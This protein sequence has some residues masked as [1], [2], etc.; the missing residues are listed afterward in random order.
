MF[1][2]VNAVRCNAPA[3]RSTPLPVSMARSWRGSLLIV[4]VRSRSAHERIYSFGQ[5]FIAFPRCVLVPKGSARRGMTHPIHQ[6]AGARARRRCE[7]VGSVPGIVR[8]EMVG[9]SRRASCRHPFRLQH[10]S[11]KW[12]AFVAHKLAPSRTVSCSR[13]V[14]AQVPFE[15]GYEELWQRQR[16][17]ARV[18]LWRAN[19]ERAIDRLLLTRSSMSS[20]SR[21]GVNTSPSSTTRCRD[22]TKLEGTSTAPARRSESPKAVTSTS[23]TYAW[24]RKWVIRARPIKIRPRTRHS[25]FVQ[26]LSHECGASNRLRPTIVAA[27]MKTRETNANTARRNRLA[28]RRLQRSTW[29]GRT[30]SPRRQRVLARDV[31]SWGCCEPRRSV[32][33][34]RS[35]FSNPR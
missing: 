8:V 25:T 16:A 4:A 5:C 14:A 7:R 34:A 33:P 9:Q 6:L 24:T 23:P 35:N 1:T 27:S 26:R 13:A 18:G 3:T 10:V 17:V 12:P 11:T 32:Q 31:G 19:K 28:A 30:L 20:T 2:Q 21:A 15:F 22:F 29:S